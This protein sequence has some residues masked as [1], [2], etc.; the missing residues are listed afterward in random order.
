MLTIKHGTS[1]FKGDIKGFDAGTELLVFYFTNSAELHFLNPP[2]RLI[3]TLVELGLHIVKNC[4]IDFKTG[5][6]SIKQKETVYVKKDQPVRR[7]NIDE[8][9]KIELV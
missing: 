3:S 7:Q 2:E 6:V 8:I 1:E 4:T 9:S 5:M